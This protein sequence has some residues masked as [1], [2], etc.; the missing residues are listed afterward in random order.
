MDLSPE[1]LEFLGTLVVF[2]KGI[3]LLMLVSER[4]TIKPVVLCSLIHNLSF[5]SLQINENFTFFLDFFLS[6]CF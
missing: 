5:K 4:K 1:E 6:S 2:P 3:A